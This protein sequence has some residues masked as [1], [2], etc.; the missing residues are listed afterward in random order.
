MNRFVG[1]VS[2]FCAVVAAG[3]FLVAGR[4]LTAGVWLCAGWLALIFSQLEK[5]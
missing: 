4:D 5:P 2:A 3:L 1:P